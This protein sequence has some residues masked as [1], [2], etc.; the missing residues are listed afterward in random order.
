MTVAPLPPHVARD[1]ALPA[2]GHALRRALDAAPVGAVG[3]VVRQG[4]AAPDGVDLETAGGLLVGACS[5]LRAQAIAAA[6]S[7][8]AAA[9]LGAEPDAGERWCLYLDAGGGVALLPVLLVAR[10]GGAA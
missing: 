6:R 10:G 3:I 2:V 1:T 9:A 5:V 4:V 8:M 7:T